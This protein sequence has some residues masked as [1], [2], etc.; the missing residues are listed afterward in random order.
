[1]EATRART[2][3]AAETQLVHYLRSK[4]VVRN[5]TP[6]MCTLKQKLFLIEHFGTHSCTGFLGKF[7]K[8]ARRHSESASTGAIPAEGSTF[9]A[10]KF[11]RP[12]RHARFAEGLL[13][14]FSV[15]RAAQRTRAAQQSY[16]EMRC[17]AILCGDALC[18]K[19]VLKCAAKR[20][21]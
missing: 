6:V 4:K 13:A 14:R 12:L 17:E 1:M 15:R 7:Q 2:S 19:A 8:L 9:T 16:V 5:A 10:Q 20:L 11:A 18:N 21:H 3:R